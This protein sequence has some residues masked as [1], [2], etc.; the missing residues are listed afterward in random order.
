M[1]YNLHTIQFTHFKCSI[2][3]FLSQFIQMCYH[4]PSPV[5]E[6]FHHSQAFLHA[7]C[8]WFLLSSPVL[9]DAFL[10]CKFGFSRH[11]IYKCNYSLLYLASSLNIMF[12]RFI[13]VVWI[14]LWFCFVLF[15]VT[16]L[17]FSFHHLMDIWIVYSFRLLWLMLL[18]LFIFIS[19][20]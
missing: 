1:R 2:W 6:H 12:L 9:G 10:P 15:W 5:L 3:W 20:V 19:L 11:F 18:L 13:L 8:D 17:C 4:H 7:H 16:T 14:I